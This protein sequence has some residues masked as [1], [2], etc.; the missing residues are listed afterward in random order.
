MDDISKIED[1][2]N[3]R[4]AKA[5]AADCN[6]QTAAASFHEDEDS[7]ECVNHYTS[8]PMRKLMQISVEIE[9]IMK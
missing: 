7:R 8:K 6:D 5:V 3:P 2:M 4:P 9:Q 1:E